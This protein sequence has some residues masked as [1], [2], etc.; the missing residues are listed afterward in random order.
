M[1]NL[2]NKL[3]SKIKTSIKNLQLLP[4]AQ[5]NNNCEFAVCP[6]QGQCGNTGSSEHYHCPSAA[7]DNS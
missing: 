1:F 4:T 6:C 5:T 7:N 3:L 2:T